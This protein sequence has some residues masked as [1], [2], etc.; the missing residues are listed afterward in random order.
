MEAAA[1]QG[2][3]MSGSDPMS[4]SL[5]GTG[6]VALLFIVLIT[7][8][9]IYN[10]IMAMWKDRVELF[11]N[12]YVSGPKMLTA[13]QNPSNTKSK[14]IYFSDNQ[15]SGIEFSYSL[16]LFIK[17]DTFSDGT[18]KLH[19]I[20]H[21]GYAKPYPLMGPGIFCWGD[22]NIIRVFMNCFDT[23]D[24]YVD[25]E[26]IPVDKWFHLT[27]TCKGN[28]LYVYI[29]GNLKNK[30]ALTNSTP[31]YQNYGNVYLFN[32]RKFSL[33]KSI[34]TSLENDPGFKEQGGTTLDFNGSFKG[35]VSRV[36]YFSYAL[37]YT[38]IQYLMNMQPSTVMDG[39]D[40]SISPYL[41]D[42]WWV[43]KQGP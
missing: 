27:V 42:T 30:M 41:S 38:E 3:S 10:S 11:P 2:I 15:R 24:N 34:T 19:H 7:M 16:F 28:T 36:Y 12:T 39:A 13:L 8:E 18:H 22:K 17:S 1:P 20:L 9:F 31:P 23:W 40:L 35:M 29:N 43:N 32:S 21:K 5:T 26:N 14:T 33:S 4:Q 25:I 37:T 6:L